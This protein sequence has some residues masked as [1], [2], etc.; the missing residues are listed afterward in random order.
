MSFALIIFIRVLFVACMVFII[1]H[2]FGSFGKRPVLKTISRVAAILVIILFIGMNIL[3]VRAAIGGRWH[4]GPWQEGGGRHAYNHWQ[5]ECPAQDSAG[6]GSTRVPA[7]AGHD[8][9]PLPASPG[10]SVR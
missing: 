6:H 8:S 10:D 7:P 1:G 2:I 3:F 5:K 4:H 9:K